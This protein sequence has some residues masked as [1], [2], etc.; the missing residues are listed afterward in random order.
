MSQ[1]E[2]PKSDVYE[3][4]FIVKVFHNEELQERFLDKTLPGTF[5]DRK[6]RLIIFLMKA[7]HENKQPISVENMMMLQTNPTDELSAF[8]RKHKVSLFSEGELYNMVNEIGVDSSSV[9]FAEAKDE[10]LK[11]SFARFVEDAIS[12]IKY[13]NSYNDRDYHTAILGKSK[14]I[15]RV[16]DIIYDRLGEKRDQMEE[17]KELINDQNEYIPTSSQALNSYLGGFTR[18]YVDAII[19]KSSHGKSSWVDWNI[20]QNIVTGKIA[21]KVVKVTPEEDA[22]TQ[23]RRYL[24]M[25]C[26]LS[27]SGMRF[28]TIKVTDEHLRT[29]KEKLTGKL[30]IHDDIYKMKDIIDFMYSVKADMLY[31][32]HIN[33]IDYPGSGT[34]LSRMIGNIPGLI[35]A[36]KRVAKKKQMS[37]INL[38]QVGDKEIQKSDR[39][40]KAPR[41]WDAY[42]SSVLYQASREYLALYY[43]YKDWEEM[44]IMMSEQP[45][46]NDIYVNIEKSSFS[47]IGKVKLFFDPEKN[48][49]LDSEAAKR[50]LAKL[51]YTAPEE[52]T[53][54]FEE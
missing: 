43:P 54:L 47:A 40:S 9:F 11:A 51:N 15:I 12:D 34:Y 32:D 42:G 28:K 24:A 20:L 50:N 30:E 37:I 13:W 22:A 7:L 18:G 2:Y 45:S 39:I 3:R 4:A 52:Q 49:F 6:R 36:Q 33:S 44:G 10:I 38:S 46:P 53:K 26:G 31:V 27:T 29:V 1:S 21:S 8:I 17:A 19:A 16:H 41:Y 25:I 5:E 48:L 35:D 14:A 23:L